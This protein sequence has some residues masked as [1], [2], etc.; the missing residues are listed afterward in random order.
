MDLYVHSY[1]C[2]TAGARTDLGLRDARIRI[3]RLKG[4]ELAES[5]MHE[6]FNKTRKL[7]WLVGLVGLVS[8]LLV[9]NSSQPVVLSACQLFWLVQACTS[10]N[11]QVVKRP[12]SGP[13]ASRT[14]GFAPT[15]GKT[16]RRNTGDN[17]LNEPPASRTTVTSTG[18][19]NQLDELVVRIESLETLWQTGAPDS[20][21]AL[22]RRIR[23]LEEANF[24]LRTRARE[25]AERNPQGPE[26]KLTPWR[27]TN[28]VVVL[29]FGV[30]KAVATYFGQMTGPTT[31]DWIVGVL[32][33]LIV[34]WVE[35][36]VPFYKEHRTED[37][38]EPEEFSL[39][40]LFTQEVSGAVL[41]IP[42]LAFLS[43][44]TLVVALTKVLPVLVEAT[45]LDSDLVRVLFTMVVL[46]FYMAFFVLSLLLSPK[47]PTLSKHILGVLGR[48]LSAW[49][50]SRP[51]DLGEL[52]LIYLYLVVNLFLIHYEIVPFPPQRRKQHGITYV[53]APSTSNENC[54]LL[55]ALWS[56]RRVLGE[57]GEC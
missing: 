20:V 29:V 33:A 36:M 49:S 34:Y 10:P 15:H 48:L 46:M 17:Q 6:A 27:V 13:P 31:A 26:A 55:G 21:D 41:V 12:M 11:K 45:H 16:L 47:L 39:H 19:V 50:L 23:S 18:S 28:T 53:Q 3:S 4:Q 7:F 24:L 1:T 25:N 8:D 37:D 35:P 32:W 43:F 40:W 52:L 51:I 9:E 56:T 5:A 44:S 2:L 38:S 30:Y 57:L 54:K 22:S 42:F 14:T